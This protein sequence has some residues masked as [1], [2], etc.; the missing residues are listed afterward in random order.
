MES[1]RWIRAPKM[2]IGRWVG[3]FLLVMLIWRIYNPIPIVRDFAFD[4]AELH[5]VVRVIDGDTI[6]LENQRVRFIGVDTP[7]LHD[8]S[9]RPERFANEATDFIRRLIGS[10]N[11]RLEF[12]RERLDK[13]D[14]VLAYVFVGDRML[15]EE[16]IRQGFSRAETQYGYSAIKKKRFVALENTAR[17]SRVGLW[18]DPVFVAQN[19]DD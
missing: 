11:V 2:T 5:S 6:Q 16:L 15:N 1:N 4:P 10:N 13:Y 14:R 9:G 18:S 8:D 3:T 17:E 12:D 19:T 7:E